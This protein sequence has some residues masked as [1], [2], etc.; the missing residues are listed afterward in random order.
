MANLK[1][2]A[3]LLNIDGSVM[4]EADLPFTDFDMGDCQ[5]SDLFAT[6]LASLPYEF[7]SELPDLGVDK[8]CPYQ[9]RLAI[10]NLT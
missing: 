1:I 2:T 9:V 4:A 6:T 7:F 8:R 3:Q 10:W 5:A